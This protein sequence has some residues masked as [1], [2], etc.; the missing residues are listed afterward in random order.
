MS[1]Q[2]KEP[3]LV[4]GVGGV[5][6]KLAAEAKK[7]LNSNC[8]VIGNDAKDLTSNTYLSMS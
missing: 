8:L 6:S 3:I 1:H 2:V 5:G 4:I 7:H